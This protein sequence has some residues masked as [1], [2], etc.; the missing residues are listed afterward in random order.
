MSEIPLRRNR[1]QSRVLHRA[2]AAEPA[3]AVGGEGCWLIDQDGR[4]YLDAS[5]G[6]AV[7]CLGHGDPRVRA[8]ILA[9]LD[10]VA[11]AHTGFFTNEPME[12]LADLL[13]EAAPEGFGKVCF[14]SGGS[15]AIESALKIARQH[16]VERGDLARTRVIAR[17]QS[18]H[19]NTLGALSATGNVG[20]RRPFLPWVMG[21]VV[22]V[23]PCHAYRYRLPG[24][25][26][27]GYGARLAAEFERELLIQGPETVLAFLAEPVVGATLGAVPAV[28]G[29]FKAIREICTRHGVLLILDEVMCG[30]GRT[31]HTFACEADGIAPD[32]IVMA[33]GLGAGYQPIGAVLV[34]DEI[35]RVIETGRLGLTTGHT[36]MGHPVACAAALAVQEAI[37]DDGLVA[38]VCEMGPVFERLLR[39]RLGDRPYVGDIRGR[40]FFRGIE[41]VADRESK[42]PFPAGAGLWKKIKE[43]AFA[44]GLICYPGGGTV[45]GLSGDHV[46]LAP[47]FIATEEEL[48]LAV[49]RLGAAIDAA[50]AATGLAVA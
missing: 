36:Y 17:R 41:L 42:A 18:Y 35:A 15:E 6:A 43:E 24:E 8:A 32:I 14:V 7:S 27:T 20:R 50:L 25:S 10:R 16:A 26:D 38:R 21:D 29:Y 13:S 44:R 12:R 40:G 45:D 37:R 31:G 39:D 11:F 22:H 23:A 49:D 48:A 34:S 4:R 28:E 5:G 47:P 1:A 19:G 30:M 33:K 46:L 3:V 9:Q 2:S